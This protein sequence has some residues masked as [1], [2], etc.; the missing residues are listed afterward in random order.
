MSSGSLSLMQRLVFITGNILNYEID[1]VP[2]LNGLLTQCGELIRQ[3]RV[4]RRLFVRAAAKQYN[5]SSHNG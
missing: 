3:C 2:E 1:N 4:V 5:Y